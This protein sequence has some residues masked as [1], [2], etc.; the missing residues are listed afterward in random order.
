MFQEELIQIKIE[1]NEDDTAPL[2]IHVNNE[3]K[4]K[5]EAKKEGQVFKK[6]LTLKFCSNS[7]TKLFLKK[8]R[9]KNYQKNELPP[10]FLVF[11]VTLHL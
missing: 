10:V 1:D 2:E 5:I 3:K 9:E 6:L 8:F 11:Q 7:H 4:K